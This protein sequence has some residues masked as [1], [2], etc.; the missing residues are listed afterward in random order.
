[1]R[2]VVDTN[3]FVSSFF[4]GPPREIINL[5]KNGRITLCFSGETL[6]ELT[7]VLRRMGLGPEGEMKELLYLFAKGFHTLFIRE[8]PRLVVVEK[9]P[10]DDK[11]IG[12]AVALKALWIITGD[13]AL[14]AIKDYLGIQIVSPRQFLDRVG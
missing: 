9:D 3:V 10:D 14:L 6:E 5:W 8:T 2:V 1:M 4:G 11:F 13:K 12:C 7:E